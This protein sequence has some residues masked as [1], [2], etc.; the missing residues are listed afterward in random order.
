M[1]DQALNKSKSSGMLPEMPKGGTRVHNEPQ[2][3]KVSKIKATNVKT[4]TLFKTPRNE[5]YKCKSI[6]N[7]QEN[8]TDDDHEYQTGF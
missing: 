4:N 7:S 8:P 5:S 3:S 6:L 2:G 1:Q